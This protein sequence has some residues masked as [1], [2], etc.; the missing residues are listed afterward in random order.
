MQI[1]YFEPWLNYRHSIVRQLAFCIASPNILRYSPDTLENS[2]HFQWHDTKFWQQQYQYYQPRLAQLDRD[3]QPLIAFMQQLKSTRLGLRFEYLLWFWLTEQDYHPFQL[4]AHSL[5]LIDGRYTLGELDFVLYNQEQQR[6]EHWEVALKYY[7]AEQDASLKH[8]YGLNRDDTLLKKLTHYSQQQFQFSH[9]GE[10]AIEQR[11]AI[12][13]GQLFLATDM[14]QTTISDIS[15]R[16]IL[17][18]TLQQTA[19]LQAKKLKTNTVNIEP[20]NSNPLNNSTPPPLLQH[21]ALPTWVNPAR[22]LGHWGHHL[23]TQHYRR[24]HRHEWL[25]IDAHSTT[26]DS[27]Y[28][29]NGLYFNQINQDYYMFRQ[30]PRHLMS[31]S[32]I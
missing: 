12:M 22:R 6:I 29:H 7:L 14:S 2:Q 30:K 10:H 9:A 4:L 25:C 31:F 27:K 17:Q 23:Y 28:W 8:W 11:F 3:P 15:Q 20:L 18:A 1:E 32:I 16:T 26:Q 19:D 24:L 21:N 5:Q 13:K